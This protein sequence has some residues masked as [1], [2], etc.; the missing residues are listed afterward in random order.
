[1]PD[2]SSHTIYVWFDALINYITAIG[3]GNDERDQ[4]VGFEKFWPALHLVGKDIS[5]FMQF[6][7]PHF[8]WLR[9]SSNLEQSWL[10]ECGWINL[11]ARCPRR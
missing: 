3:Y 4:A 1:M 7:G 11:A 2:D 10:M 9:V 8:C 6:T 5:A